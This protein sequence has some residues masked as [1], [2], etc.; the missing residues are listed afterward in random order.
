MQE[1]AGGR[2]RNGESVCA[3]FPLF[4]A[5]ENQCARDSPSPAQQKSVCAG[6][7]SLPRNRE[8]VCA[9]FPLSRATENWCAR[10]TPF[11]AQRRIS[12]RGVDIKPCLNQSLPNTRRHLVKTMNHRGGPKRNGEGIVSLLPDGEVG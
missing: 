12:V 8:S 11:P 3:G 4:R 1:K 10:D 5:K 7:T 9:G 2:P 6:Y